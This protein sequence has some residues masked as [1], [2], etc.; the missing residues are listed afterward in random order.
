MSKKEH[1][2]ILLLKTTKTLVIFFTLSAIGWFV[3]LLPFAQ[4]LPFLSAKLPIGVFLRS[5][6]SL[7]MLIVM[8]VFGAEVSPAMDSLLDFVPKAG[9]LFGNL[10]KIGACLFA[11]SAF[12]PAVFPFIPGFEWVYQAVLL[13]VILFFLARAGLLVYAAS[14]D[15]SRFLMGLFNPYRPVK[16]VVAPKEVQPPN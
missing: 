16:E 7:L 9:K 14:E 1:F 8:I 6:I 2:N 12:Q 15:I 10:V 13:G 4:T 5:V 3:D 11:Y